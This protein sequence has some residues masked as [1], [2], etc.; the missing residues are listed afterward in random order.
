M[1]VWPLISFVMQG[2]TQSYAA[3]AEKHFLTPIEK[4]EVLPKESWKTKSIEFHLAFCGCLFPNLQLTFYRVSSWVHAGLLN[5]LTSRLL[6]CFHPEVEWACHAGVAVW[7]WEFNWDTDL[8][9][10]YQNCPSVLFPGIYLQA[11]LL[12]DKNSCCPAEQHSHLGSPSKSEP[13]ILSAIS[14]IVLGSG[15]SREMLRR[16]YSRTWGVTQRQSE[17]MLGEELC[18]PL[19]HAPVC[20]LVFLLLREWGKQSVLFSPSRRF[21]GTFG[22]WLLFPQVLQV[23]FILFFPQVRPS[24]RWTPSTFPVA[25][26]LHQLQLFQM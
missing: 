24:G 25:S 19:Q 8:H 10:E 14:G 22:G 3:A 9:F 16:K 17:E 1:Q 12:A 4:A 11:L 23:S 26:W 13:Q 5:H 18:F 21:C 2:K 20:R 7:C 15:L 6:T